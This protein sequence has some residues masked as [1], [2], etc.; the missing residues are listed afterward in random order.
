MKSNLIDITAELRHETNNS[1]L[2]WDG[3]EEIKKGDEISSELRTWVPKSMVEFDGKN[4]FTMP[5]WLAKNKG[6]I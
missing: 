3:R 1:Y 5:T 2:V 4:I 6:F